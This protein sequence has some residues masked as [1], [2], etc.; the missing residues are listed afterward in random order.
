[1]KT[2]RE[3]PGL[4]WGTNRVEAFA[5]ENNKPATKKTNGPK[6]GEVVDGYKYIGGDVNAA[7]SWQKVK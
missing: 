3:E 7:D 5:F 2:V 6:V 4:L 1:M